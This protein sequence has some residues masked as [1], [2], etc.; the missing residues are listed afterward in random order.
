MDEP[1]SGPV[2]MEK[3]PGLKQ[4][5]S[6]LFFGT[7]IA[8]VNTDGSA[9]PELLDSMLSLGI[10]AFDCARS[11][12]KAEEVLGKWMED[13]GCREQVTV[14]S[15][16]GDIRNGVVQVNRQVISEQLRQSLEA[17]RTDHIDLY[18]LH[19]DDPDTPIEEF[20]DTLNEYREMGKITVFG[21]SNWTHRRIEA[22]NRYALSHGLVPFSVSSPNYGLARQLADPF[23]GG[24]VT[25]SGPE[26]KVARAWYT[27]NQM[28]VIAY[29]SMGRGFFSGR[30]KSFDYD[31][32]RQILDIY[33]QKGYLY[34]DNMRILQRAEILA[35]KYDVTVS[36]IAMRYIFG[37]GMNL[38]AVVSTTSPER[39]RMNIRA[40]ANPLTPADIDFLDST[41]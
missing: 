34:E 31:T 20:I 4:S 5:V 17:L 27:E 32:A 28:P 37:S 1:I 8:P 26:N 40:A 30:F 25:V 29:S 13:R 6:R 16:C 2:P 22:A 14:L 12:G 41:E 39:M 3:I 18:L 7:A 11:Y 21:V 10:N 24:C 9:A 19:R 38:F 15:K 33:A 36:E 35:E 23:G